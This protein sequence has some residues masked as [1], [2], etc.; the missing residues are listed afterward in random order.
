M[1]TIATAG[2]PRSAAGMSSSSGALR[3]TN[4]S[5]SSSGASTITSRKSAQQLAGAI[6][7]MQHEPA[8]HLR[9]DRVQRELDRGDDAE[10]AAAA[11]Q[12]PE[13]VGVLVGGGA[14]ELAAR[15]HEL[16]GEHVVGREAVL[17]LEPARA[18]RRA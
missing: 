10:V 1:P 4:A 16:D 5:E 2:L 14:D 11:A 6:G 7:G 12:R 15:G 17:A 13:Q 18:R 9:A 8:E 3:N